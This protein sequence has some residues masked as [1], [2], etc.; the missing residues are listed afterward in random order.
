[1]IELGSEQAQKEALIKRVLK[2]IS[3]AI[4]KGRVDP[5]VLLDFLAPLF[6]R[7]RKLLDTRYDWTLCKT[8]VFLQI[9]S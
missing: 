2:I 1:M 7:I 5:S 3:T 6:M 8:T 9:H 4:L